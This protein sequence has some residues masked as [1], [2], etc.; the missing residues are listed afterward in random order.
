MAAKKLS[1]RLRRRRRSPQRGTRYSPTKKRGRGV[2][3]MSLTTS[4]TSSRDSRRGSNRAVA[5]KNR[6]RLC[7]TARYDFDRDRRRHEC[8]IFFLHYFFL[9]LSS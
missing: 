4:P 6:G 2:S 9:L 8:N 3:S 1:A 7:S 5:S